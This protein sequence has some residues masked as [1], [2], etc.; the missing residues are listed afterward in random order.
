[1]PDMLVKLYDLPEIETAAQFAAR[2]GI[3]I[4]RP[5]APEKH[6]VTEWVEQTFSE[7]WKS[8][9]EAAFARS[10]ISCWIAAK[11]GEL[12]GFA[13]YD[14]TMKGFFADRS[15]AKRAR[16]RHRQNPPAAYTASD[17]T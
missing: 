9:C 7:A 15:C 5:I 17:E 11:Q 14:A 16:P 2:T 1:M 10:P 8:E 6:I 12:L 3:T 13:C 4:R